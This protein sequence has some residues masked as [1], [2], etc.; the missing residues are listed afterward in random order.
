MANPTL[1]AAPRSEFGK[2]ACRRIRATGRVP[3]NLYGTGTEPSPLTVDAHELRM[4]LR[5]EGVSAIIDLKGEGS[6]TAAVIRELQRE[7]ITS[8]YLHVDFLRVDMSAV[9]VF[10][11]EIV[12]V[13]QPIGVKEGG[14][15]EAHIRTI[16]VRCLPV[17]L[18][19]NIEIDVS[20]LPF[21][22][23]LMA[24]EVALPESLELVSDENMLL[25]SVAVPRGMEE[26]EVEE[27]E[28]EEGLEP[29]VVG[30]EGEEGE[31]GEAEAESQE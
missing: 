14:I 4:L 9:S 21:H 12:A 28:G 19:H 7:P 3:V 26:A 22:G 27:V 24:R 5:H 11:V 25:F 29:D 17:D 6:D 20:E 13:G 31:E 30:E 18:P 23:T 1:D 10:T 2:N 15:L 8:S 16:E